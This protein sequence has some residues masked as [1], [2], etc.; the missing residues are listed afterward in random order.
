MRRNVPLR[1][2]PHYVLGFGTDHDGVSGTIPDVVGETIVTGEV[3]VIYN[4]VTFECEG[5]ELVDA[6]FVDPTAIDDAN[7]VIA[8]IRRRVLRMVATTDGGAYG[9]F[10]DVALYETE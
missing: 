5:G 10:F 2:G 8:L 4:R 3:P 6:T 9:I 7:V 1:R